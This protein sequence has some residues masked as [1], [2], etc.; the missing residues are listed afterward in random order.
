MSYRFSKQPQRT[1]TLPSPQK[2]DFK[3]LLGYLFQISDQSQVPYQKLAASQGGTSH[4]GWQE[5]KWSPAVFKWNKWQQAGKGASSH[6]NLLLSFLHTHIDAETYRAIY[7]HCIAGREV[8]L[9][10]MSSCCIY[11]EC[12]AINSFSQ[13]MG[14][15][16]I[17]SFTNVSPL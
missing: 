1:Q 17:Y 14:R 8:I 6:D 15:H 10:Q 13:L 9:V 2:Q 11:P 5:R 12:F 3:L 7:S 16:V 4:P